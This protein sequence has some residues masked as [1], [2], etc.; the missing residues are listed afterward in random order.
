M[1][2]GFATRGHH[3]PMQPGDVIDG[4]YEVELLLGEGGMGRVVAATHRVLGTTVAIK[5]LKP[6][7]ARIPE[8]AKR[9]LREARAASRLRSEHVAHVMDVGQL[10]SGEPYMVMQM[11]HGAD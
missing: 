6:D 1:G 10:Q 3:G 11:L 9:F 5:A 7:G 4:K 8:V 2:T